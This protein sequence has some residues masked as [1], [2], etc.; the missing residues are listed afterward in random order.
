MAKRCLAPY[1]AGY[2]A[3]LGRTCP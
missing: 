3:W 1:M 2:R